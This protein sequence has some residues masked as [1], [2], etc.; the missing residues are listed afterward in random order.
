MATLMIRKCSVIQIT[1]HKQHQ[2]SRFVGTR[3]VLDDSAV[4]VCSKI[5][6]NTVCYPLES[7]RMW[8]LAN[9]KI[10]PT[11]EN[12]FRGYSTYLPYTI[13][14]NAITF[15]L[16]YACHQWLCITAWHALLGSSIITCLVTSL[17]K[18]PV[19]YC[20]KRRVIKEDI[21]FKTLADYKYFSTAYVAL[22]LEDIPEL[23]IKFYMKAQFHFVPEPFKSLIIAIA[24]T[25]LLTPFEMYKTR[26]ICHNIPISY[27]ASAFGIK[28]AMSALNTFLFFFLIGVMDRFIKGI[29][30]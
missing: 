24:S 4:A 15:V 6:A 14:N 8:R 5:I 2:P 27:T 30:A 26:V 11:I 23:F 10:A 13:A 21:C 3:S 12:L 17:Y 22:L 7:I 25:A 9:A 28:L 20:L 16:F 29:V 18:V 19:S 1:P